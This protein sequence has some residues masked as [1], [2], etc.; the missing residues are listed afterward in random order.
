MNFTLNLTP[1]AEV[2]VIMNEEADN[3]I[4]TRGTGTVH[5]LFYNKGN[6]EMFGNYVIQSGTYKMTLQDF[7]HK[8]FHFRNGGTVTFNGDP[9]AGDLNL[10]AVYTVPSVSLS[11]LMAD[12]N[13]RDN[14]VKS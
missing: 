14:S 11:D 2:K 1:E 5:A 7:I 9:F 3:T 6:F 10:Q 4:S 8:D 13:L 12:G